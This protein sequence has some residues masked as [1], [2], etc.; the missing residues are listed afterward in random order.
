MYFEFD[1]EARRLNI[2][3]SL[4]IPPVVPNP[5]PYHRLVNAG[6]NSASIFIV[7]MQAWKALGDS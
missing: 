2:H 7:L 1:H 3:G 5:R 4:N 6:L